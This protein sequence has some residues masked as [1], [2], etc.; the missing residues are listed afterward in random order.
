MFPQAVRAVRE[1]HPR[2]FVFEDVQGLTRAVFPDYFDYILLQL[3]PLSLVAKLKKQWGDHLARLCKLKSK[4]GATS[5][6]RGAF[7]L[8]NAT[9]YGVPQ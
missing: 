7:K 4:P 2:A 1:A 6:Y 9:N 8:V 5:D 3:E